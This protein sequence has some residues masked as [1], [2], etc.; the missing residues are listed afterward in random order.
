MLADESFRAGGVGRGQ[1]VGAGG[2]DG[3]DPV[4]VDVGGGVLPDPGV[5]VLA[6]VPAEEGLAERP[7]VL[8]RA[9]LLRDGPVLQG[10]EAGLGVGVVVGAVRLRLRDQPCDRVREVCPD[11]PGPPAVAHW[12]IP[13][14]AVEAAATITPAHGATDQSPE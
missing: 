14:P 1:D 7:G 3:A 8:D 6:V 4:V 12:S 13:D 9:E 11:F 5:V 10:L 2:A